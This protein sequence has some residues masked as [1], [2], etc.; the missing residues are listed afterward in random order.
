[1]SC[2]KDQ[3]SEGYLYAVLQ[4]ALDAYMKSVQDEP[5][6]PY[7]IEELIQTLLLRW[8]VSAAVILFKIYQRTA[9]P[10]G[11]VVENLP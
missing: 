4:N 2:P 11:A 3:E 1:M 8:Y 6:V 10:R 5:Q 9:Q 7:S